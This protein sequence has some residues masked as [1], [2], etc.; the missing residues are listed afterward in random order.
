ME[1]EIA[2]EVVD[3]ALEVHRF[4]GPG[5]LESAYKLMVVRE[6]SMRGLKATTEV[7]VSLNYKGLDIDAAYRMDLLVGDRVIVELKAV[8]TINASHKAQLLS[9]LRLTGL[10]LGLVITFNV[11]LLRDGITRMVNKL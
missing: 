9:Y 10:K 1:N 11:P 8:E 7:P 3:A 2:K 4:A 6:L 5:L